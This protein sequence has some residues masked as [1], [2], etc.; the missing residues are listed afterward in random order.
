MI[1]ESYIQSIFGRVIDFNLSLNL[2][3]FITYK[4]FY[5]VYFSFPIFLFFLNCL[6]FIFVPKYRLFL[7]LPNFKFKKKLNISINFKLITKD[8]LIANLFLFFLSLSIYLTPFIFPDLYIFNSY[9][10][11]SVFLKVSIYIF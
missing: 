10:I 9:S 4:Y 8:K 5:I 1:K 6:F 11:L 3:N 2:E 7:I